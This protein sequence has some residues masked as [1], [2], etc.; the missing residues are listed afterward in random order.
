VNVALPALRER[1]HS[2]A[3]RPRVAL[4][5]H[6]VS[7]GYDTTGIGVEEGE[8]LVVEAELRLRREPT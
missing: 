5:L 1:E 3:A 2:T 6:E 4:D 7:V 8:L